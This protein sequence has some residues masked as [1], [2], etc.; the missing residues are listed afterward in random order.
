LKL[1]MG[2]RQFVPDEKSHCASVSVDAQ[3]HILFHLS[4][5]GYEFDDEHPRQLNYAP[6]L[7]A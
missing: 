2:M 6:H 1:Q 7:K 3:A 4:T 5:A